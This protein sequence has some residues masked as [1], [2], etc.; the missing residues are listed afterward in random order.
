[1]ERSNS[2]NVFHF[3]LNREYVS[4]AKA[5]GVYLYDVQGNEY[6]DASGGPILCNLGHGIDE[7]SQILGDQAKKLSYVHRIDFTNS[8]LEEAAKKI[9]MVSDYAMEK[10]FFVSEIGRASCRERVFRAL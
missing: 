4:I 7:M 3:F 9:C 5:K 10:V 2:S 1:M 8:P 6:L